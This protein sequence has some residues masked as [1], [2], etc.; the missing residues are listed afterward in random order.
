MQLAVFNYFSDCDNT[1]PASF[2]AVEVE[3]GLSNTFEATFSTFVLVSFPLLTWESAEPASCLAAELDFGSRST[4]DAAE[5]M[6]LEVVFL[7]AI[8]ID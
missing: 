5:A 1:E 4:F 6:P 7:L 2:F 8:V 3:L